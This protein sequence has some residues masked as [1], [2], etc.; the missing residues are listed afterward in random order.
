MAIVYSRQN[1]IQKT[2]PTERIGLIV[3]GFEVPHA[4]I[5]LIPANTM[6]DMDFNNPKLQIEKAEFEAIAQVIQMNFKAL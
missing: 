1:A 2:I 6:K 4:H 5:H 3:A